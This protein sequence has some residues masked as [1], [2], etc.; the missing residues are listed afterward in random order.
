M[1]YVKFSAFLPPGRL[2]QPVG[3]LVRLLAGMEF[4][5]DFQLVLQAAEVPPCLLTSESGRQPM[6]GW[7]TWLKTKPF[8]QDDPQVILNSRN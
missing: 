4:D 6:L 5:F 8:G 7:T 2:F 1:N 3:E